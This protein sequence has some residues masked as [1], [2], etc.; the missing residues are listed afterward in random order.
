VQL[1]DVSATRA[2]LIR[3][4]SPNEEEAT[5]DRPKVT[6]IAALRREPGAASVKVRDRLPGAVSCSQRFLLQL[7]GLGGTFMSRRG[8]ASKPDLKSGVFGNTTT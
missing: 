4:R 5:G 1:S 3:I 8:E 7:P 2:T 6:A